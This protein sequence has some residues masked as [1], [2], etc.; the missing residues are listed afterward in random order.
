MVTR[1][2]ASLQWNPDF[3]LYH[4]HFAP[5]II[6]CQQVEVKRAYHVKF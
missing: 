4:Y 5:R 6:S 1:S 3:H 2:K